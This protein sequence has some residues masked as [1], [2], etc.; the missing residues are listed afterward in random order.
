[1]AAWRWSIVAFL[2]LGVAGYALVAG[3]LTVLGIEFALPLPTPSYRA[4]LATHILAGVVALAT[5]PFQFSV[6]L[7]RRNPRLHRA[8][9]RV[10]LAGI[11]IGGA[12][13]LAAVA[14]SP[15]SLVARAGFAGMAI[16]W[17]TT[18]WFAWRHAVRRRFKLHRAWVFR[19]F[20]VTLAAVTLRIELPI[21][22]AIFQGF[23]PAYDVVA[24]LSWVPNLV[25]AEWIVRRGGGAL[26]PDASPSPSP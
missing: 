16:A 15:S 19:A 9:G 18:A 24:W 2:S 8:L 5:M 3:V 21:L 6:K 26:L 20:A 7:R 23:E 12:A 13:A 4:A 25:V 17:L 11:A 10:S 14:L 1:M 22:I